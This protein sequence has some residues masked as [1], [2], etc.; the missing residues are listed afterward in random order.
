M[1]VLSEYLTQSLPL[2]RQMMS[3]AKCFLHVCRTSSD[4]LLQFPLFTTPNWSIVFETNTAGQ[5]N[6]AER[7]FLD[8]IFTNG[9]HALAGKGLIRREACAGVRGVLSTCVT[10]ESACRR[11]SIPDVFWPTKYL[12]SWC[13]KPSQP[14]RISSGLRETFIKRYIVERTNKAEIWPEKQSENRWELSGELMKWKDRNRHKSV[15]KRGWQAPLVY[16]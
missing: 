12:A 16:V 5:K 9:T 2:W 14:Q 8:T 10:L 3:L 6:V 1:C 15:I 13:F 11:R 4:L 7:P